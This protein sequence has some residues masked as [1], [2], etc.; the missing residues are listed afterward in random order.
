MELTLLLGLLALLLIIGVPVA[1]ALGLASLVTFIFM[2][3]APVVAF[4]RIATGVNVFSLMAI[5]FFIFA[6]DLMQQAGIA[7]RLV[8]VADAAMGR[9]R[10]GLGVV[11]VGAS[12][13]FGGVSGSAVASVSAL[14][15]TL[16]PLMKEKGYDAD[17]AVNVTSTSAIL[18]ILI[19]P[20]HNM[21]IYAA[22]AGVSVSVA[23][24]FL[25]GVLPGILTGI[26][27]AA[28]AWIIAVRR[29]YPKGE[30]PGWPA[31]AAA[32]ASALP[33]LLTAVIIFGGVL[34]GVFTPTESSAVAVI[35]TLVIAVIVYRTL[36]FR[37]FTTAAQNAVKTTAMV[38][39]IIGSAAAFGWLLALLEAPEQ[40]ATL[41]Q[42]LT[43]NPILILLLINLILLILGT[44]MDMAPLIVITSPIFLPVAM[45][46]GMDPVQFGIMMMLNLGIGLVTPPVGSVLFVGC[47]VG[48]IKVE[49]AVR[50]IWP[51][52]LALFAALMAIT[53]V[54]ALTL[55]LPGL[56]G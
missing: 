47:A 35:Y 36:G 41:L 26:F 23:D 56:A 42:T 39:L 7:E 4:Q 28:A 34:G 44:F 9:I 49:Q 12:M 24:L 21:I 13:M 18:G 50:T 54:P 33:G 6:G 53:F 16:I 27:L 29:G 19:P 43:D 22:A 1:F 51:F 46:T 40:L 20:S 2:D 10:G 17:Y 48:K 5:P 45:A 55:T 3:I 8:R 52:Y 11:D 38:M 30:F 31:F 32:F 25:A 14:G 37:G 15:S